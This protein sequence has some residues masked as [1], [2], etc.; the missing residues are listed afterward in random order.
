ML[1]AP[2][3]DAQRFQA[4][5]RTRQY[6][7]DCSKVV[8]AVPAEDYFWRLGF[9]SQ[10][11]A[12]KFGLLHALLHERIYHFPTTHY[13]NPLRCPSRSF[14]CYFRRPS[15]CTRKTVGRVE[16]AAIHWCF[17]LPLRRLQELAG[18][19]DAHSMAW[20]QAQVATFLF[21]PNRQLAQFSAQLYSSGLASLQPAPSGADGPL[22]N[23]SEAER[24]AP[25]RQLEGHRDWL[26]QRRQQ[27]RRRRGA[28]GGAVSGGGGSRLNLS[29]GCVAVHIRRTDKVGVV[30]TNRRE[31]D[32][33]P[34]SW[35]D[36]AVALKEWAFWRQARPP[37]ELAVVLG[38]ED[39]RTFV[40]FPRLIRPIASWWVTPQA[41][42]FDGSAG[43]RFEGIKQANERLAELYGL[44]EDEAAELAKAKKAKA[45]GGG[46]GGRGGGRGGTGKAESH[47]LRKDEGMA[48]AAQ[49][50]LMARCDALVGSFASNVAIIV[51]D[52]QHGRWALAREGGGGGRG[53][54]GS[55]SGAASSS[56]PPQTVDVNGRSYCGCGASFCMALEQRSAEHPA[57]PL[58]ESVAGFKKGYPF[59]NGLVVEPP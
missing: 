39:P 56:E 9:A 32:R 1:V 12:M 14:S 22:S 3:G 58:E 46:G 59:G 7:P 47:N 50:L 44:M 34:K 6:P 2:A 21:R 16:S 17:E 23:D 24:R 42:V 55:G 30:D 4:W 25:G 54:N 49:L 15:N 40:H 33:A 38:S 20:Y 41:F 5:I 57:V 43:R 52:L 31:D 27:P 26:R 11:V 28:A 13:A 36:F 18:L 19:H 8:G 45:R 53:A 51:H 35:A 37:S 29:R 48:L 10:L